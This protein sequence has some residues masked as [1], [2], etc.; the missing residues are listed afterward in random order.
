MYWS[1]THLIFLSR[2]PR[3]GVDFYS[4]DGSKKKEDIFVNG[5]CAAAPCKF[6]HHL[7]SNVLEVGIQ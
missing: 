5:V 4:P 7:I 3:Y 2:V 6:H 1:L